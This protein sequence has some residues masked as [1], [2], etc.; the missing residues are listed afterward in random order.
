MKERRCKVDASGEDSVFVID[1]GDLGSITFVLVQTGVE[2]GHYYTGI[3]RALSVLGTARLHVWQDDH[4]SLTQ[5]R[6]PLHDV[7]QRPTPVALF[8]A[9]KE[10]C[11]HAR[12]TAGEH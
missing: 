1:R 10:E 8:G 4:N 2:R 3:F 12:V 7:R 5:D 11:A 9:V 6:E